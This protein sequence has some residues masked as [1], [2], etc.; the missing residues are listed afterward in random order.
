MNV[1][2]IFLGKGLIRL[3]SQLHQR[4]SSII[5]DIQSIEKLSELIISNS[6]IPKCD[7]LAE[8]GLGVRESARVHSGL[9]AKKSYTIGFKK[10]CYFNKIK[11]QQETLV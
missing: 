5:K 4:R 7:A 10:G 8:L 2:K 3:S 9:M 6:G 1:I 11:K